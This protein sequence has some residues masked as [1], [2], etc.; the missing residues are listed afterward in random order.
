MARTSLAVQSV[1]KNTSAQLT[2][3]AADSAN[4]MQFP[5]DGNTSLV[6]VNAS[7]GAR[8][9]TVRSVACSHGRTGDDVRVLA[10][11]TRG[12]FGPYEPAIFNQGATG[13]VNLDFDAA[14][15]TTVA[16]VSKQR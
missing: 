16:C 11:G 15:S 9:V 1:A 3:V 10:A 4:G 2:E 7:G 12:E 5:N 8:T 14:T 13:L 6:V